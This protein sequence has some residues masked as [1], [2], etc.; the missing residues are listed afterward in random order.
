VVPY[1]FIAE[2]ST[3]TRGV[4]LNTTDRNSYTFDYVKEDIQYNYIAD[5]QLP[6]IENTCKFSRS[7]KLVGY[8]PCNS[9]MAHIK[10]VSYAT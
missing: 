3:L 2:N 4:K 1:A 10:S 9:M 6:I 8:D 7:F 5:Y